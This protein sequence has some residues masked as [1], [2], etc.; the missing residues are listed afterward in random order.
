VPAIFEAGEFALVPNFAARAI[1]E[2]KRSGRK[3]ALA[4]DLTKRRNL[5]V[6]PYQDSLLGIFI[7][8]AHP[9]FDDRY[10]PDTNWVEE[11]WQEK[12]SEPPITRLF[13]AAGNPDTKGIMAFVYFLARV[14]GHRAGHSPTA[15]KR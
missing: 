2:V 14:A 9:L 12:I 5:L 4:A 15:A 8:H 3:G 1:I 10:E 7:R 13:D 11:H 6:G